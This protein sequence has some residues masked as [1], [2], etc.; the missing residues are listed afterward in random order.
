MSTLKPEVKSGLFVINNQQLCH[1][2]HIKNFPIDCL[3]KHKSSYQIKLNRKGKNVKIHIDIMVDK[4]IYNSR[5]IIKAGF[6]TIS[7]HGRII[8]IVI[9]RIISHKKIELHKN[10]YKLHYST[11]STHPL[12]SLITSPKNISQKNINL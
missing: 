11:N 5:N 1:E 7:K 10:Y 8:N 12:K 9:K 4:K 3:T 2:T 6:V